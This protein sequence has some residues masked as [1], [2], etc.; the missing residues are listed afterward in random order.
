MQLMVRAQACD[1]RARAQRWNE[2]L[3]RRVVLC[4]VFFSVS[5]KR[6]HIEGMSASRAAWT[7]RT[8]ACA[9]ERALI[10]MFCRQFQEASDLHWTPHYV[11]LPPVIS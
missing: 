10:L 7:E 6:T 2:L 1:P 9:S 11:T 3:P 8:E 5:F 4:S